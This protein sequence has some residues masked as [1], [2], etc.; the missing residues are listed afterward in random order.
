MDAFAVRALINSMHLPE[1]TPLNMMPCP[2]EETL[3]T[4]KSEHG[5]DDIEKIR[6]WILRTPHP[7]AWNCLRD[8]LS[9]KR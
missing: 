8:E 4:D 5:R 7:A 9:C 3:L 1:P 6:K 2:H